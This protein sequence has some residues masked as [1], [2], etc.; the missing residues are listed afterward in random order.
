MTMPAL[1]LLF[2]QARRD[3]E[4]DRLAKIRSGTCLK[5][6]DVASD[7]IVFFRLFTIG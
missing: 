3:P 4:T 7:D 2:G 1:Q 6:A 5:M